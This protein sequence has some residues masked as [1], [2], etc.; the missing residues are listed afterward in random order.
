M[1]GVMPRAGNRGMKLP[2][3]GKNASVVSS[4]QYWY[5]ERAVDRLPPSSS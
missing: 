4:A 5:Y 1:L 2:S 3:R